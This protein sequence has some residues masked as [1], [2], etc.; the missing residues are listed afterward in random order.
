MIP[1]A[2]V[3]VVSID[4]CLPM[5]SIGEILRQADQLAN[6]H[7]HASYGLIG[8][9]E[10]PLEFLAGHVARGETQIS[11]VVFMVMAPLL[12]RR[13]CS[14]ADSFASD[15]FAKCYTGSVEALQNLLRL[16]HV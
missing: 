5:S 16:H 12:Q 10:L 7:A 11:R 6:F 2:K 3:L 9:A 13:K 8:H 4:I 14:R 15:F 1:S